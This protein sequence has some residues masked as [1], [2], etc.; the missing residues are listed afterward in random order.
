MFMMHMTRSMRHVLVAAFF[1][2]AATLAVWT[3]MNVH[4]RSQLFGEIVHLGVD[5]FVIAD[6]KSGERKIYIPAGMVVK[7]GRETVQSLTTGDPVV[8]ITRTTPNGLLEAAFVRIIEQ[9]PIG[10]SLPTPQ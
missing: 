9:K 3:Y 5:H 4:Q 10:R 6:P 7:K 8:V 2:T 1:I